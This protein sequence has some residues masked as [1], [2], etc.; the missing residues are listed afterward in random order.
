MRKI[1]VSLVAVI[2]AE[3]ATFIIVGNWLGVVNTLLLIL[4][5]SIVGIYVAKKQGV[6]SFQNMN[7]SIANGNPPGVAMIDTFL[8]FLGGVLLLFP[9]FLTDLLGFSL[10]FPI[11]RKW[12]KPVI[13]NWIR[14]RMKNDQVIIINK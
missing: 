3:I 9:G 8:V 10:L 12:F 13:Y 7:Q 14:N 2:L 5:T 6:Q 1:I 11:T 4:L